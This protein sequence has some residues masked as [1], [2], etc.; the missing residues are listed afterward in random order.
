MTVGRV[1]TVGGALHILHLT[2]RDPKVVAAGDVLTLSWLVVGDWGV[3]TGGSTGLGAS[4]SS[5]AARS[6]GPGKL[7][8]GAGE[9]YAGECSHDFS[10]A[11]GISTVTSFSFWLPAALEASKSLFSEETVVP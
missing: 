10:S 11:P 4:G 5:C 3:D 7:E 2:E 1:T 8:V 9:L 6:S